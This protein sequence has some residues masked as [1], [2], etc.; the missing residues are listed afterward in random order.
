MNNPLKLRDIRP[1]Y[2]RRVRESHKG[3]HG[4]VMIVGGSLDYYGAP[5]FSG[6]GAIY[7]GSDL[8]HLCVPECNFEVS[9]S[10]TL[11]FLVHAFP[12]NYLTFQALPLLTEVSKKCDVLVIGPGLGDLLET[13]EAVHQMLEQIHLPTLLDASAIQALQLV[14]KFPLSQKIIITPHHHELATLTGKDIKIDSPVTAKT[15]LLRTLARDLKITIL[16]KG[17]DDFIVSE[18]GEVVMNSTG[19]AGMT[20][21]GS[22]DVL[23]GFIA[24]IMAQ[25]ADPFTAGKI[26]TF[27][28]GKTG[29]QLYRQKGYNFS[30]TD[31]AYELPYA[32]RSHIG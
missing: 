19:N 11:D 30:A 2:P 6:L 29:D 28:F 16:L 9:R 23:S 4:R 17:P 25:G 18:E 22:G 20:V 14:K 10:Q 5:Q 8:V 13:R 15:A 1:L 26:A 24:S 12:G 3:M 27:L 31:L 32:I 7:S 21:G